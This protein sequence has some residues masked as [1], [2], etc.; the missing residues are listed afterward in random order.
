MSSLFGSVDFLAHNMGH[1]SMRS[2]NSVKKI[3]AAEDPIKS[4]SAH[5]KGS[6]GVFFM[7]NMLNRSASKRSSINAFQ[8]AMT[9]L[10]SQA[11]GLRQAEKI[12]DQMLSLA[13]LSA[14]PMI[15]DEDRI[16]LSEE[17]EALRQQSLTL[18][19][20]DL[21]GVSLFDESAAST[22]YEISFGS[23]LSDQSGIAVEEKDV[24]YS[25]G[26]IVMDVNGGT[27]GETY[28]LWQGNQKLF[29]S[30]NWKT[31]GSART[32]DYDR[33]TI[34]F[35]PNKPTTFQF[36]PL[37]AGTNA[38][39]F[40]NDGAGYPDNLV[41]D[42]VFD[43]KSYY[44]G[45]LGV[46]DDGSDSGWESREG[47]DYTTLGQVSTQDSNSNLTTLR[48][49]VSSTSLFQVTGRYI[50]PESEVSVVG[51]AQD[52]QVGLN[53]V[54]LG[55]L[56]ENDDA[57]GFPTISIATKAEAQKALDSMMLEIQGLGEQLGRVGSNM[58]R[59]ETSMDAA[60]DQVLSH[61]KA[62]SSVVDEDYAKELLELSKT[63]ISRSQNGALLTQAMNLHQDIV[64]I[65]I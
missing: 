26:T 4:A 12:Y 55:L 34:E 64:N 61:E 20:S 52:L 37:S 30:G 21:N 18:A 60:Q 16:F 44:L 46:A 19:K 51:N 50:P 9:F 58:N 15:S 45:Q 65:L 24:L 28:S 27:A 36:T 11:D 54:G 38:N 33:F 63:R 2:A 23:Q 39:V 25:S 49:E 42:G 47:V 6:S 40:L 53:P 10:Q 13:S 22:R 3:V 29:D 48:L 17:F 7:A 32:Y 41:D 35:G 14:D 62:L 59:V 31:K 5:N 57:N 56:R 43:N 1:V 8:N